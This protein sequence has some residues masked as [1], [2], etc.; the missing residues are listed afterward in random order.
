[1]TRGGGV[2]GGR[3]LVEGLE[4][5]HPIVHRLPALFQSDSFAERFVGG[6]DP[7]LAPIFSTLDNMDAYFDPA[8]TPRDFLGWLAGW[9]GV[10]LDETW[11][12]GRQRELVGTMVS[13][14]GARG[15][16]GGLVELL[17]I[18]TG[19]EPEVSDSGGVTWSPTP[20]APLPGAADAALVVRVPEGV[21][22]ERVRAT[23]RANTPAHVVAHVEVRGGGASGAAEDEG[24]GEVQR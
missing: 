10:E 4:S 7:T 18:T 3:G 23:V 24:E 22:V 11:P 12:V 17:R 15:T 2:A 6:L 19:E 21:D 14:Y 9:V 16:L 8:V 1:M 5:A 20:G 13:L